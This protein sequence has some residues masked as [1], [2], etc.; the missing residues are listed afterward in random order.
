MEKEGKIVIF[1]IGLFYL[2]SC[3]SQEGIENGQQRKIYQYPNNYISIWV[4]PILTAPLKITSQGE[5]ILNQSL[6][7]NVEFGIGYQR[8]IW[9]NLS[10][11]IGFGYGSM[12]HKYKW[13]LE[14]KYLNKEKYDRF[15]DIK[16]GYLVIPLSFQYQ[17]LKYE[18]VNFFTGV[19]MNINILLS[20]PAEL[21]TLVFLGDDEITRYCNIETFRAQSVNLG[22]SFKIGAIFNLQREN[23][24]QLSLVANYAPKYMYN[25]KFEFDNFPFSSKGK[26]SMYNNYLGLLFS[27]N[28]PMIPKKVRI[29]NRLLRW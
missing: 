29:Q 23:T 3:Y 1:I 8:R 28:I 26:I 11:N 21:L 6:C 19:G 10:V 17:T 18:K 12:L 2:S 5:K 4:N 13:N 25:G 9:K 22:C 27:Y 14:K 16:E 24:I 7:G 20:S 15:V